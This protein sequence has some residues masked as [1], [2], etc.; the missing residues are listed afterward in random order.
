MIKRSYTAFTLLAI[1]ILSL[2]VVS[3][4]LSFIPSELT[5]TVKQGDSL[6]INFIAKSNYQGQ[7]K[8]MHPF[9]VTGHSFTNLTSGSNI[10]L[11]SNQKISGLPSQ[12]D[13]DKN[14]SLTY[15]VTVPDT[16]PVGEYS[17]NLTISGKYVSAS[18]GVLPI[19]IIVT[20]KDVN[21][22]KTF[23]SNGTHGTLEITDLNIDNL[24]EG[25]DDEWEPL[26]NIE[27]E[28]DVKNTARQE[29]VRNVMVEIK[30]TDEN[31][32]DV[33]SD[34]DIEDESIDLGRIKDR[35]TETAK[36]VIKE[37]PADIE[38]GKYRL[39]FKAYSEDDEDSQCVDN[40]RRFSNTDY[41]LID[42]V[43]EEDQA[44][45][46]RDVDLEDKIVVSCG[47][48]NVPI[49]FPVYN[50]GI[51]KEKKVLVNLYNKELGIDSYEFLENL[52]SGKKKMVDFFVNIPEDAKEGKYHL[53]IYTFYDYD[54]GD[55]LDE[56]SYDQNSRDDL[57]RDF[58]KTLEVIGCGIEAPS[59]GASLVS[60]SATVGSPLEVKITVKNNGKDAEFSFSLKDFD[61]WAKLESI[62]PEKLEIK[63]GETA[64]VM[65]TL[66]PNESGVR[67]F[68]FVASA[69][70]EEFN[71]PISVNVRES[72][73]QQ[74]DLVTG[75]SISEVLKSKKT[76]YFLI[77]AI[78]ILVIVII[79]L[80]ASRSGHQ[81]E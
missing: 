74:K 72:E 70:D 7:N 25:K 22:K 16:T 62:K 17:G 33:T 20:Q 15:T 14:V 8:S 42:Y 34:F 67:S 60:E 2:V 28:V 43:R 4:K 46:V 55:E 5:G 75:A 58:I 35:D 44:V 18:K 52:R 12:F 48:K 73:Q 49:S 54:K 69:G 59:I 27:I 13:E 64:T 71:Q 65:V 10:I 19:K 50:I 26:D 40:S 21:P 45:I 6:T 41:E 77:A 51:D 80:I 78:V 9:I 53:K 47:Q 66:T 68:R 39:Y 29:D 23:C 1:A 11:D 32:V 3:A 31:G 76:T 38:E 79:A 81:E 30:I 56:T 63:K 24:G 57:E 37:L 61:S 36:F